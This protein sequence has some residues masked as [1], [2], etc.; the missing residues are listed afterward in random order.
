MNT[1]VRIDNK[2]LSYQ[3]TGLFSGFIPTEVPV[4]KDNEL[5]LNYKGG[6]I[7]EDTWN[8]VKSFLQYTYDIAGGEGQIRLFYN[9]TTMEWLAHPFEQF[10]S[11]GLSTDE[12]KD[13]DLS[14]KVVESMLSMG[15]INNGTVHHHCG[16]G[17]FQS[18]T[19]YRDEITQNGLHITLGFM[20][21]DIYDYHSRAVFRGVC[22]KVIDSDWFGELDNRKVDDTLFPPEWKNFV[23]EKP[24]PVIVPK[25]F[26]WAT[27][28]YVE[29]N[30]TTNLWEDDLYFGWNRSF[31][32]NDTKTE[33]IPDSESYYGVPKLTDYIDDEVENAF[34]SVP[35]D[36]ETED[37][38]H[39]TKRIFDRLT[40]YNY[41]H[42]IDCTDLGNVIYVLTELLRS[43]MPKSIVDDI[44]DLCY[45]LSDSKLSNTSI[46]RAMEHIHLGILEQV[47]NIDIE[48]GEINEH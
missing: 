13:S 7:D 28:S 9:P 23:V 43:Q 11:R 8:Q 48:G 18:G 15:Y 31:G 34:N 6:K 32:V 12:K 27:R 36:L 24:V 17:A 1:H 30:E 35:Q 33:E 37:M 16:V 2:I 41:L 20:D 29:R 21:R 39:Y 42:E 5:V 3:D 46:V 19:D 47:E 44:T 14:R 4:S 22:Y 38:K 26:D 25:T 40:K 10:I 45:I